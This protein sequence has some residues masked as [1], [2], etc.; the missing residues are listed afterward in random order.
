MREEDGDD[1]EEEA[2]NSLDLKESLMAQ[3]TNSF[4]RQIDFDKLF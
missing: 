1:E 4:N 2:F 3:L